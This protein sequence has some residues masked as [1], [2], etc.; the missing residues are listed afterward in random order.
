[1]SAKIAL[2]LLRS[3]DAGLRTGALDVL[4]G[5]PKYVAPYLEDLLRDPDP[6][7]RILSCELVRAQASPDAVRLLS[8]VIAGDEAANVCGAAIG[9]LADMA[10][11]EIVPLLM[12]CASRFPSDPFL[13]FSVE[14]AGQRIGSQTA[15]RD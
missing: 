5:I 6:D 9:V 3:D 12:Q 7:V 13:A 10:G 4:R 1:M 14:V 11:T 15:D 2:P 8:A